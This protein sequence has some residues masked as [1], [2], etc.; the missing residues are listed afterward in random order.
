[1]ALELKPGCQH[2]VEERAP[3]DFAAALAASP[4]KRLAKPEEIANA[5]VFLASA[6]AGFISGVNLVVDE[7][8]TRR[9]QN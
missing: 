2:K 1:M 5:A 3:G 8:L 6:A 4:M 9:I 7:A